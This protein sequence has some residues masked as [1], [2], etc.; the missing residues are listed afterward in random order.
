MKRLSFKISLVVCLLFT[1]VDLSAQII[2]T[3]TPKRAKGQTDVLRLA[4]EPIPVVQVAIV[5]LG[6]RGTGAV[7]R[8]INIEGVEIVALCD[9]LEERTKGA[10]D[11]LVK[12]GFPKATEFFGENAWKEVCAL[13]NVDLVYIVTDWKNHANIAIQ[14]MKEGKNAAV[15]VPGALTMKEIWDIIDT[16]EKTRKH[17]M[18]LE[19]CV[20][21]F[22]ELTN[23]NMAPQGVF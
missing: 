3:A 13:K 1:I 11:T 22:F 4:I 8:M 18:M 20:Y 6:M 19:N 17:C 21:D 2:K 14:A 12:H 7:Q 9:M 15:E 10:N 23:L 5:G 16:S